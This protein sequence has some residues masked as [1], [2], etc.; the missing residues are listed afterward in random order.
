MLFTLLY[1]NNITIY[2]FLD[3]FFLVFHSLLIIFVLFGWIWKSLRLYH[4][5][6]LILTL[7]SW[8]ILSYLLYGSLGYCPFTDWHF[9]ALREMG[10]TGLPDSY[11]SYL[12]QRILNLRLSQTF[13]DILTEG[14]GVV[15]FVVSL[16]LNTRD[17]F[18]KRK[19]KGVDSVV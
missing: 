2:H 14:L 3:W 9:W 11:V 15:A 12:F 8:T 10:H 18:K 13:V 16:V 4:L 1:I 19:Q 7:S 5:I 6:V 17:F